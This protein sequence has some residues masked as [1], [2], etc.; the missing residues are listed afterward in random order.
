MRSFQEPAFAEPLRSTFVYVAWSID[1][2]RVGPFVRHS[3][4]RKEKIGEIAGFAELVSARTDIENLR[5]FETSVMPPLPD[6]PKYDVILLVR[7]R[8]VDA[9]RAIVGDLPASVD[10]PVA[11]FLAANDARFGDT[12]R[13][14]AKSNILLNHF[15]GQPD[16]PE[17]LAAWRAVSGWYVDKLGVDNSTLLGPQDAHPFVMVNYVRI[18]GRVVAFLLNQLLRPSFYRYVRALLAKN[19]LTSLPLFV[20]NIPVGPAGS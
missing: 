11:V 16:R 2:A 8:N 5:L 7:A 6:I 12:E 4:A 20:K 19:E 15:A 1:P 14:T 3:R 9:A 18:P 13:Q 17:A 10:K